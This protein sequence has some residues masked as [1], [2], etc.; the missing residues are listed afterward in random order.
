MFNE[1]GYNSNLEELVNANKADESIA[2]IIKENIDI[3][4]NA[5]KFIN[6]TEKE[7]EELNV[8]GEGKKS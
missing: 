5:R 3:Q 4:E 7:I 2:Y 6:I 1:L 8:T